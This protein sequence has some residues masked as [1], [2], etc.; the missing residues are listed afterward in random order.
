[1]AKQI[2]YEPLPLEFKGRASQKEFQFT[3]LK[4]E[5]N[6]AIYK[7]DDEVVPYYETIK[8]KRHDGRVMPGGVKIGPSEYYPSD[9]TFGIDGWC[10][11]EL[12]Q[13]EKKFEELKIYFK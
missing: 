6:I 11:R 13:A 9:N 3:Q 2:V 5:G 12:S 10:F 8:V 4:R 1:M 7:K